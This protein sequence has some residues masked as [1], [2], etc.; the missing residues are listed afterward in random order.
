MNF[1]NFVFCE[2]YLVHPSILCPQ[3]IILYKPCIG[4]RR[5]KLTLNLHLRIVICDALRDLV[6]LVQF[7]KHEKHLWRSVTFSKVAG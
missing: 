1:S 4:M 5:T 7:K 6:P 3:I 2:F